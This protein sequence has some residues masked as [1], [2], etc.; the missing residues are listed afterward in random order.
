MFKN[1]CVSLSACLWAFATIYPVFAMEAQHCK[2]GHSSSSREKHKHEEQENITEGKKRKTFSQQTI[3]ISPISSFSGFPGKI[4]TYIVKHMDD[5][6]LSQFSITAKSLPLFSLTDLTEEEFKERSPIK[7]PLALNFHNGQPF[8]HSY[9]LRNGFWD[10][11]EKW[12]NSIPL[13][14]LSK[15]S[16]LVL[17]SEYCSHHQFII[18]N[19]INF[20]ISKDIYEY[21]ATEYQKKISPGIIKQFFL[22]KPDRS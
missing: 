3:G 18:G 9:F 8:K 10:V 17:F 15:H 21:M 14:D 6:T 16:K 4:M 12:Y 7:T 2:E 5:R 11:L 1:I 20:I 13:D 19:F 22:S